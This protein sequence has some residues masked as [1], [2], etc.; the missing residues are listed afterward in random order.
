MEKDKATKIDRCLTLAEKVARIA[1]EALRKIVS[2]RKLPW[3]DIYEKEFWAVC[4]R[5]KA[6]DVLKRKFE[7]KEAPRVVVEQFLKDTE[8]IL[9]GVH[10][11]VDEFVGDTR[12]GFKNMGDAIQAIS[13]MVAGDA[14]LE[15]Q[16]G[17]L[18]SYNEEMR[19]KAE[20]TEKR[21]LEQSKTIEQLKSRLRRDPLTG[22]LNRHALFSDLQ[23]ELSRCKRY[24]YPFSV[25]MIDIDD[26]KDINDTYGHIT[27][28]KLLKKLSQILEKSVRDTDSVYRYGGE[29]FTVL[30]THTDCEAAF[31]LGERL[32]QKVSRYRFVPED[33]TK[34]ITITISLG[35]T[36]AVKDD[37]QETLIRRADEALYNSKAS[38]KDQSTRNCL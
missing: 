22:L 12:T 32:R 18:V 13:R 23:K 10:E 27:G 21:L 20:A 19:S 28:D 2:K 25:I 26:F 8:K 31:L 4:Y 33:D 35:V 34:T 11:T 29:E 37:S 17:R 14:E 9:G 24:G 36:Q 15:A 16:L 5:E 1:K 38:G 7:V 30:C 3:P 6:E